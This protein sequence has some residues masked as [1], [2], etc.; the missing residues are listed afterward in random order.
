[1][2]KFSEKEED[3]MF[4]PAFSNSCAQSACAVQQM[5]LP[6]CYFALCLISVGHSLSSTPMFY[7]WGF[8][9][10]YKLEKVYALI[11]QSEIAMDVA[12][13]QME[14]CVLEEKRWV[15]KVQGG[16]IASF[17]IEEDTLPFV[18]CCW[19]RKYRLW[20]QKV[21]RALLKPHIS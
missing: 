6:P 15:E 2:I 1:M 5:P 18:M 4:V 12:G 16:R 19:L 10:L 8:P 14:H 17:V 11:Y 9:V 20:Y 3:L 21:Q 7:F 13:R